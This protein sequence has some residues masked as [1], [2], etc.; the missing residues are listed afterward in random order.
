MHSRWIAVVLAGS[1]AACSGENPPE[2]SPIPVP[3]N[4]VTI[5]AAGVNPKAALIA[6][7]QRVRFVNNDSRAHNIGSDPHP[8]HGECPEIDQVGFLAPGQQRET[9]NFVIVR[10]CGYHDHDLPNVTSLQGQIQIR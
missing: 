5:T 7:G 8:D 2:P 1:L 9:G 4:V 3:T 6:P 10:N